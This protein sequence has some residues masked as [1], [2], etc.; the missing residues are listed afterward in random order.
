MLIRL[1]QVKLAARTYRASGAH[2]APICT[3]PT[4]SSTMQC[5]AATSAVLRAPVR[6]VAAKGGVRLAAK[7]ALQVR[8]GA[9]RVNL[10]PWVI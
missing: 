1:L 3:L 2:R 5:V 6:A 9:D 10:A 7:P 4:Y 8:D